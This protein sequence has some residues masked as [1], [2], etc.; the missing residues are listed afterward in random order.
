[1]NDTEIL[2]HPNPGPSKFYFS[3]LGKNVFKIVIYNYYGQKVFEKIETEEIN[4][5]TKPNGIYLAVFLDEQNQVLSSKKLI[6]N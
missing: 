6:K 3:G 2:I 1:M 4:L 5:A